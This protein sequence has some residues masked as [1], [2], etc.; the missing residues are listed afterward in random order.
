MRAE[1]GH[2]PLP[3][4]APSLQEAPGQQLARRGPGTASARAYRPAPATSARPGPPCRLSPPAARQNNPPALSL[5]WLRV[6]GGASAH[7]LEARRGP[8]CPS[9]RV[10]GGGG[11]G[12]GWLRW[13]VD[14]QGA[15]SPECHPGKGT[16]GDGEIPRRAWRGVIKGCVASVRSCLEMNGCRSPGVGA[17]GGTSLRG[18]W[19]RAAPGCHHHPRVF[20]IPLVYCQ[21]VHHHPSSVAIPLV[22]SSGCAPSPQGVSITQE[23]CHPKAFTI[24]PGRSLPRGW[25]LFPDSRTSG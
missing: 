17:G 5:H 11:G 16:R 12:R 9:R 22:Y 4:P 18:G 24:T 20:T 7:W 25:L 2:P 10:G 3:P 21:G 13:P 14:G 8:A 19:Q 15:A 23:Y 1:E 6:G